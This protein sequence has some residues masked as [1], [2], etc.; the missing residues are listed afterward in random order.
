MDGTGP[1]PLPKKQI[2]EIPV[3]TVSQTQV[4][5][6][7]NFLN[8]NNKTINLLSCDIYLNVIFNVI[9]DSKLQCSVC[10]E[11]FMIEEPVRQLPCQHCYHEACIVPWLELVS[12]I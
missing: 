9:L 3:T 5:K 12:S 1:P 6:L 7:L 11:D 10:W 4:G 2:D 8:N